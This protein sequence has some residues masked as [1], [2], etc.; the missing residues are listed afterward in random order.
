M[1]IKKFNENFNE[2]Y[3]RSE[4]TEDMFQEWIKDVRKEFKEAGE[5]INKSVNLIAMNI[6]VLDDPKQT[7]KLKT[8][9]KD[10]LWKF[11]ENNLAHQNRLLCDNCGN[12]MEVYYD[13]HCFKCEKP[14]Q[15]NELNYFQCVNWLEKNE[16]DFSKDEL[17][18]YL[19]D[20]EVI[21]GNDT[22]CKLPSNSKDSNMKIFMK[23]FD[24]K[25][26]KYFVS[27]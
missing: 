26:A 24:T 1:R 15:D 2:T 19:L 17:W 13:V 14:E 16:E 5:D 23:H 25:T 18:D 9:C 7:E 6:R 8:Q 4:L 20:H 27:W 21:Q 22:Y 12:P 10:N 3:K 11:F